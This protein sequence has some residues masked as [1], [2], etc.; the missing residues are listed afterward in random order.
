MWWIE[1]LGRI[2]LKITKAQALSCSHPGQCDSDVAALR[3]EP[4]IRRQLN[5]LDAKLV[6][7]CLSEYGAWDDAELA[8]HEANLDRLLWVACCDIKEIIE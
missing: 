6:A 3:K 7:E 5:K 2:E 8:D 1:S 4:A